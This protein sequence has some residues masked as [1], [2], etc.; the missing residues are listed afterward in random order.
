[1]KLINLL[2]PMDQIKNLL[3]NINPKALPNQK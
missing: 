3:I 2:H 1:M